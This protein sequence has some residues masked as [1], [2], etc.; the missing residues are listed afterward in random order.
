[1]LAD[2]KA[3]VRAPSTSLDAS[4]GESLSGL[5]AHVLDVPVADR[6]GN[7]SSPYEELVSSLLEGSG[8]DLGWLGWRDSPGGVV[9]RRQ[10]CGCFRLRPSLTS[11]SHRSIPCGLSMGAC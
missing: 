9:V 11:L 3:T 1:M 4:I 8:A 6:A 10:D 7:V 5:R 2:P